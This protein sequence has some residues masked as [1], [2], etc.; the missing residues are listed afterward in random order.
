MNDA[1]TP[2]LAADEGDLAGD[3]V[4]LTYWGFR[5]NLA[6]SLCPT[7]AQLFDIVVLEGERGRR[8]GRYAEAKAS[9]H[10][11]RAL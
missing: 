8:L 9:A 10:Q 1:Y 2:R 5:P 6:V 4:S 11:Y 7:E 3:D